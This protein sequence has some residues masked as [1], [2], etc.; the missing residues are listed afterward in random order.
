MFEL[1]RLSI[2]AIPGALAKAE[3]YRLLNEPEQARSICEDILEADPGNR[4][5]TSTL[6]LSLTDVFAHYEGGA[7]TRAQQLVATLPSEYER[8]YYGGLV[9]ERRGRALLRRAGPG[10]ARPAGDLLREAMLAF[11][12]A[13]SLKPADTDDALLRWNACARML[14]AHT[15]LT[16]TDDD[17]TTQVMLE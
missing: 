3:R 7:V 2:S 13:E 9:A 17:P 12:R 10:R 6:I 4:A 15:E 5:A 16:P 8:L 1:K 14:N 11:E